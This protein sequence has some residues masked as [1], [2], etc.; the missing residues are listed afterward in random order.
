LRGGF[1]EDGFGELLQFG[2]VALEIITQYNYSKKD[3]KTSFF[4]SPLNL[5]VSFFWLQIGIV[6]C[7]L[8]GAIAASNVN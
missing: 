1:F 4:L 8:L 2:L 5:F 7:A 6:R 3:L